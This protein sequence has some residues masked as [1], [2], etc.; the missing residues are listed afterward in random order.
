VEELIPQLTGPA[1]ALV[2]CLLI[3]LSVYKLLRDVVAPMMQRAINRH[4]DQVDDIIKKHSEEHLRIM[5]GLE[6]IEARLRDGVCETDCQYKQ[7]A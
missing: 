1:S 4:L 6:A 2:V 5:S 3:G 7:G